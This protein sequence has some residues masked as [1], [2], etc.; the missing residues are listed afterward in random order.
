MIDNRLRCGV[1]SHA[2]EPHTL[3]ISAYRGRIARARTRTAVLSEAA[4]TDALAEMAIYAR[5]T[6]DPTPANDTF[7]PALFPR[8]EIAKNFLNLPLSVRTS[9]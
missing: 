9:Y 6:H 7:I 3:A 8:A 5:N 1:S 2:R 4:H